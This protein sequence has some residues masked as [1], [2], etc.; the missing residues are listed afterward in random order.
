MQ[1]E[2]VKA[3]LLLVL[4]LVPVLQGTDDALR[5]VLGD[6]VSFVQRIECIGALT[7]TVEEQGLFTTWV[8]FEK[9]GDIDDLAVDGDPDI[10]LLAVLLNLLEGVLLRGRLDLFW[11]GRITRARWLRGRG[12]VDRGRG[13]LTR[14]L[15]GTLS[16]SSTAAIGK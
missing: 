2:F 7:T 15:A 10:F 6:R 5:S 12:I 13:R 4:A 11:V 16:L 8:I 9:V 3:S 14:R 1:V